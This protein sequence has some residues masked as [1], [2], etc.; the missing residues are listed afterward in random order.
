MW[1][2]D[3]SGIRYT[4]SGDGITWSA[5][6]VCT[7][8]TNGRHPVVAWT[9]SQYRIWY[10]NSA[11]TYGIDTLRTAVSTDAITWTSDTIISQVGTTVITGTWPDWNT[12]SYGPCEIFYN[13]SGSATIVSPVDDATVWAN[14]YVMYYDGTTGGVEDV[15]LAV[16]NDGINW[17]GLNGGAAPV[18]SHGGGSTWDSDYATMCSV[19]KI[20]GAYHM[21]YSGGQTS[22]HEGIGYAQSLDGITWTKYGSNPI[23]HMTD[24]VTWRTNRTYTPR[25]LFDSNSFS[26]AGEAKMLKMWWTGE[27][28]LSNIAIGYSG[29]LSSTPTPTTTTTSTTTTTT[30]TTAG[31][32]GG[33]VNPIDKMG[34]LMPYLYALIGVVALTVGGYAWRRIA[35]KANNR[36]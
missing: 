25:V 34:L 1:Y 28:S 18:L 14:K 32:V 36:K 33:T 23:M 16:S 26:G 35:A 2:D 3:G 11:F 4:T 27:D 20:D 5:G 19:Q 15:G 31:A 6:T 10:W 17:E 7:G 12:G 9:G 21:W 22:S 30:T 13:A 24:G 8:F 29:E